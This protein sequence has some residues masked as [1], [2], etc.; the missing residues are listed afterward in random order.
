MTRKLLAV[1]LATCA[2][3]AARADTWTDPDTGIVWYYTYDSS[4]IAT[5]G[6]T[7]NRAVATSTEGDITIPEA[8]NGH[9]VGRIFYDAFTGCNRITGIKIPQGVTVIEER[10]FKEC[11]ALSKVEM[12]GGVSLIP[13][14]AFYSCTNLQEIVIPIGV[15][16]IGTS[17]F[18]YCKSLKDL[19]IPETVT[20]IDN[21]AFYFCESLRNVHMTSSVSFVGDSAFVGC[22][23]LS[24]ITVPQYVLTRGMS[25]I[26]STSC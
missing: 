19:T 7:Y 22:T 6:T 11:Y 1:L 5:L 2:T 18:G 3:L 15:T 8:L 16:K 23:N 20:N 17:A 26:F 14:Q 13:N 10:A 4:G 24:S 21:S 25:K 9:M 12:H